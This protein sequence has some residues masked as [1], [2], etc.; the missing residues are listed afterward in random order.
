MDRQ[1]DHP[2]RTSTGQGN[3]RQRFSSILSFPATWYSSDN[4]I[5]QEG[6]SSVPSFP[7]Q[8]DEG[9]T[10]YQQPYAGDA[11]LEKPS[12]HEDETNGSKYCLSLISLWSYAATLEAKKFR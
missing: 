4:A 5:H 8:L 12:S 11:S 1:T 7:T 6:C 2:Q 3:D 10:S 9:S